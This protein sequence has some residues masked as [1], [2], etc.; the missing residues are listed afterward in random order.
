MLIILSPAKTLDFEET[1]ISLSTTIPEYIP[2]SS[3]LIQILKK[4]SVQ[5]L[6]EL[7]SLSDKLAALNVARY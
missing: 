3:E 5:D 6:S 1:N 7:M 2:Q 4:Y